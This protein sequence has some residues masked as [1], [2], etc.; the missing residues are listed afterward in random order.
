M[1]V[2]SAIK[3]VF[4]ANSGLTSAGFAPLRSSEA[5][6]GT[7]L[8]YAV[9]DSAEDSRTETSVQSVYEQCSVVVRLFGRTLELVEEYRELFL[10]AFPDSVALSLG[11]GKFIHMTVENSYETQES[12]E[13]S[14]WVSYIRCEVKHRRPKL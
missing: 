6:S 1:S 4:D 8:P 10:A 2:R 7:P 11:D 3:S 13:P 5:K 12:S 9:I 14:V